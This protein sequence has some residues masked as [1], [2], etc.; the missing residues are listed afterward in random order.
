M[1]ELP[2]NKKTYLV[3]VWG[4]CAIG[5]EEA[6]DWVTTVSLVCVYF[7]ITLGE[8]EGLFR[9]DCVQGELS[10][11]LELAGVAMAKNV[12]LRILR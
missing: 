11:R 3:V 9:S 8:L 2:C 4:T 5:T 12:S 7:Q 1:H 10:T 6:V